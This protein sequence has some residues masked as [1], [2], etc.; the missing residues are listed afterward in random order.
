MKRIK[1]GIITL[2]FIFISAINAQ[3]LEDEAVRWLQ[4]FIRI[5]TINPP[6]NEDRAVDFYAAIFAAEGI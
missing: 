1:I 5:D 2:S 3:T 4:E 6:G